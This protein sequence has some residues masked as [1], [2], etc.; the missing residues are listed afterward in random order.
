[1]FI[2][3]NEY[4]GYRWDF[5][6]VERPEFTTEEIE[7]LKELQKRENPCRKGVLKKVLWYVKYFE[8]QK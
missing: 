2:T 6:E 8:T 7:Y 5:K 1:M 4:L 3:E